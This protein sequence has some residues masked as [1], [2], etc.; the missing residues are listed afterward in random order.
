MEGWTCGRGALPALTVQRADD[1]AHQDGAARDL[2]YS[3]RHVLRRARAQGRE[4]PTHVALFL[5]LVKKIKTDPAFYRLA[6]IPVSIVVSDVL[7]NI[8]IIISLI[9]FPEIPKALE[10]AT[11]IASAAKQSA[12]MVTMVVAVMLFAV[13]IGKYLKK[14]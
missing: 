13:V 8:F 14:S 1:R 5:W 12:I 9:K 6:L 10:S 2:E 3:G 11:A 7:E 4:A